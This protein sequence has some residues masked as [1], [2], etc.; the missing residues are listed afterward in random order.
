MSPGDSVGAEQ[1]CLVVEV[2]VVISRYQPTT[3]SPH[4]WLSVVRSPSRQRPGSGRAHRSCVTE[5]S[6]PE[7]DLTQAPRP[8]RRTHGRAMVRLE[9]GGRALT[10]TSRDDGQRREARPH[11]GGTGRV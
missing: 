1:E 8:A 10:E 9:A 6:W 2:R 5:Q 4:N 7:F 11:G 3:S